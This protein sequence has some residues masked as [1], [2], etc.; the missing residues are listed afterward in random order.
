MERRTFVQLF[1]VSTA[2]LIAAPF[3]R[4]CTAGEQ[5][6]PKPPLSTGL[7]A[8]R[9]QN[10]S[11]V[12]ARHGMVCTSQPLASMAGIDILQAGGSAVDAAIA[13]NAVLGLVEPMSCGLGG[14]LFAIIWSEKDRKLFGLNASG[15][16]PYEW[17][18]QQAREMGLKEIPANS[19]LSWSVP[20]C[21]SGWAALHERFG[22]LSFSRLMEPVI[23]HAREGFPV[24]PIIAQSWSFGSLD[25]P[26]LRSTY[27]PDGKPMHYGTIFRNTQLADVFEL[28]SREG[29]A[30]FYQGQ[31]AERIV[32]FSQT[33]GGRFSLRDFRDHKADWVE[34]VSTSYRGYDVWE[35][36]P[37]G[38]GIAVLQMLNLLEHFDIRSMQPNSV[39][40]LHLF[41]EAKKLAFEDRAVYYADMD[42]AKVPLQQLISKEYAAERAKLIDL[43]RAAQDVQPGRLK[44]SS[45][46]IYMT[47]A[48]KDGNMVSLIQSNYFGWGSGYVPDGLGFCLQ[49]RGQLF[50]LDPNH[51]N[52]LEPHKHPFH[53]IIPAFVTRA[54]QPVF[55]FGVMGGDFQPQGQTQVLT[56]LIDFGMSPQQAGEQPRIEHTESSTPTGSKMV[57]GGSVGFERGIS[58]DVKLKLAY[59]GHRVR[60]N[61]GAFG[62][63]QGI[64]RQDDPLRYFGGSDPRKDGCAVGY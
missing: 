51:L 14:D 28:L 24:S 31:P 52:R 46:T 15:R 40:H 56:N 41:I 3:Y 33:N 64:W 10:R 13:A 11:T 20:G 6:S 30:A 62:G 27:L 2:T 38:Q 9:N 29:P 34:P 7:L 4:V 35:L 17:N 5:S 44:G 60:P 50:A 42:F 23:E 59:M 43:K 37:N 48:D 58:D 26:G 39:E 36:P 12:V 16:S 45:D 32:K 61:L 54:G 21:V 55:S 25:T 8:G 53:T 63:Y 49:N 19:P 22:R 18:L 57:G 1:G 47:T